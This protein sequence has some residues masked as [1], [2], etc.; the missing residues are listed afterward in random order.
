MDKPRLD[1]E[2]K[3][4]VETTSV[5]KLELSEDILKLMI[6]ERVRESTGHTF[7]PDEISFEWDDREDR[8][9]GAKLYHMERKKN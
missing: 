5:C 8:V 3:T 9:T 1:L 6:I 4:E 7:S 2:L